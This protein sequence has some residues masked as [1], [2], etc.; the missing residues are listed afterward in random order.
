MIL[1]LLVL[2]AA[3]PVERFPN[4][5]VEELVDGWPAGW[6]RGWCRDGAD[7]IEVA[8]AEPGAEGQ[9]CL[10]LRHSGERDWSLGRADMLEV[11]PG[12]ILDLSVRLK[13]EDAGKVV[14]GAAV[15]PASYPESGEVGVEWLAGGREVSG[16]R[17]EWLEVTT[18][19]IV[20]PGMNRCTPRLIGQGPVSAWIDSF[21]VVHSGNVDDLRGRYRGPA[22]LRLATRA[23]ELGSDPALQ[24]LTVTD[25]RTG[26]R[27]VGRPVAGLL[28]LGAKGDSSRLV[29]DAEQLELRLP[30]TLR[31]A[32]D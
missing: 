31:M 4:G 19:F 3:P 29:L 1:L 26:R 22:R 13:I 21:S 12:D 23:L 30:V 11:R 28:V 10:R 8:V 18:R 7:K 14:L 5:G 9:R 20:A 16:P 32:T 25:R 24:A 15:Y 27:W 17:A 6:S 2:G